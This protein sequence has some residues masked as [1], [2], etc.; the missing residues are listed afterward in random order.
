[1]GSLSEAARVFDA[2]ALQA[3]RNGVA[4]QVYLALIAS[5]LIVLWTGH[6]PSKATFEMLIFYFTGWKTEAKLMKHLRGLNAVSRLG[7]SR[8][9]G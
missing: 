8:A 4:I 1:M 5:I 7:R 9:L 2:E 3:I 6:K